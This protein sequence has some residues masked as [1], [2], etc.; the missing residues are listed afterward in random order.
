M[1]PP[2]VSNSHTWMSPP[3]VSKSHTWM[4]PPHVSKSH[5]WMSPPHVSKS[6][7]WMSPPHMSKSHM[8]MS[9]PHVSNSHTW[10]SPPHMSKS[11]TWM[12]LYV[13]HMYAHSPHHLPKKKVTQKQPV[14]HIGSSDEPPIR[15]IERKRIPIVGSC[16]CN[17]TKLISSIF[18]YLFTEE[19]ILLWHQSQCDNCYLMPLKLFC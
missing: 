11:H 16:E 1:P 15:S 7:T 4:S 9:P 5:T 2:H 18:F 19:P 6:H 17:C 10:M 12:P 13:T 8:W 14:N 3:H